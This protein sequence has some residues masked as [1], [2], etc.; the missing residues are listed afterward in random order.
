[1]NHENFFQSLIESLLEPVDLIKAHLI[2]EG[3]NESSHR[4]QL[5][6]QLLH[7]KREVAALEEQLSNMRHMEE[8]MKEKYTRPNSKV[9]AK[10]AS[11]TYRPGG[12]VPD[13]DVETVKNS[14]INL[15]NVVIEDSQVQSSK[16]PVQNLVELSNEAV[17]NMLYSKQ[18]KNEGDFQDMYHE[19]NSIAKNKKI[20][21]DF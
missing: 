14:M 20:Q 19:L 18:N 2:N 7:R 17:T 5:E 3:I 13:D 8:L 12:G 15:L 9:K 11:L 16:Q 4:K 10:A 1:M 6:L 21:I